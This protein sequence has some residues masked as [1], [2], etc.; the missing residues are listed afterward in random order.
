MLQI[1]CSNV[2]DT[3]IVAEHWLGFNCEQSGGVQLTP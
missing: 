3:L 1:H 2:V